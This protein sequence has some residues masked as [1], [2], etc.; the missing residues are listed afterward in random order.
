MEWRRYQIEKIFKREEKQLRSELWGLELTSAKS[1]GMSNSIKSIAYPYRTSKREERWAICVENK[2]RYIGGS[3]MQAKDHQCIG[4]SSMQANGFGGHYEVEARLG[5]R[6]ASLL[7]LN[8][9]ASSNF[10][11]SSTQLLHWIFKFCPAFPPLYIHTVM[12]LKK[13]V[14]LRT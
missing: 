6:H 5:Q 2:N 4:G 14:V 9:D 13:N 1:A 3:S 10:C 7:L 8:A 11:H 12:D